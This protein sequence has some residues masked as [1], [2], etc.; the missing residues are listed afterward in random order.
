MRKIALLAFGALV[1]AGFASTAL[2]DT[3]AETYG[4]TV[5][6]TNDKGETSKLWFKA[7]GTY[8]GTSAKG[9]KFSG[10]FAIKNGQYCSTADMPANAPAGTPAP[11]EVCQAYEANHKV[12]ETWTQNDSTGKPVKIEIKAG[13]N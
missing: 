6:A 9:E 3:M 1:A 2:A 8:T 7:D 12:G 11:K 13:M 5:I 10:K 4:N